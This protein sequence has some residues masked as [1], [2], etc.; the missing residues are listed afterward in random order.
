MYVVVV[1]RHVH[2]CSFP[3]L[4]FLRL[5]TTALRYIYYRNK[6][7]PGDKDLILAWRL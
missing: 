7:V 4:F 6:R 1:S 2:S 3:D 5:T